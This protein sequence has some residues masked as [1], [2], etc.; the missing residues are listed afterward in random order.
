VFC[1]VVREGSFFRLF[2]G[3]LVGLIARNSK[4]VLYFP[5]LDRL[6]FWFFLFFVSSG[7]RLTA[8]I[9]ARFCF[10]PPSPFSILFSTLDDCLR[11]VHLVHFAQSVLK[12]VHGVVAG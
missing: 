11:S 1:P 5:S 12:L 6:F 8:Q 3:V 2:L 4:L 7:L 9:L 10:L